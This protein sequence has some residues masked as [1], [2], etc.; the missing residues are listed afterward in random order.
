MVFHLPRKATAM[1]LKIME[2][3]MSSPLIIALHEKLGKDC[4]RY[5]E[6]V[7]IS[8][9][10]TARMAMRLKGQGTYRGPKATTGLLC[11]E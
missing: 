5:K 7:H 10:A 8:M 2:E 6:W 1:Y 9:Y 4:L 11:C 3:I